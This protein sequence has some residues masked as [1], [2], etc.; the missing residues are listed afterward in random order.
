MALR[1]FVFKIADDT[2]EQ[3]VCFTVLLLSLLKSVRVAIDT[4][5]YFT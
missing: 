1:V 2:V 5:L 3:L 4:V